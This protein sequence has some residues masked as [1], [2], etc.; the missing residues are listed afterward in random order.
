[1]GMRFSIVTSMPNHEASATRCST[2]SL[3]AGSA[4]KK[5]RINPIIRGLSP[6]SVNDR[7]PPNDDSSPPEMRAITYSY[8]FGT[9]TQS[10][11]GHGKLLIGV[12]SGTSSSRDD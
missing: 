7:P 11:F 6:S 10:E 2:T 4:P 12:V 3:P 1:M 5:R 9:S 8:R